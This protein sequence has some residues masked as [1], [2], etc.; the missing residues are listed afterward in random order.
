MGVIV[1]GSVVGYV[2]K[3]GTDCVEIKLMMVWNSS[4]ERPTVSRSGLL[5]VW[6]ASKER[7]GNGSFASK[8]LHRYMT[9][10]AGIL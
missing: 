2:L 6:S 9:Q 5:T 7:M 3:E 4:M 8:D 1:Q 10:L